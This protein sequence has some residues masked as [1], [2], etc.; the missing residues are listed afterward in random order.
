VQRGQDIVGSNG[1]RAVPDDQGEYRTGLGPTVLRYGTPGRVGLA[2]RE[3]GDRRPCVER[4]PTGLGHAL[5][6]HLRLGQE[7]GHGR[8]RRVEFDAWQLD[9][10]DAGLE[11]DREVR[12]R[13]LDRVDDVQARRQGGVERDAYGRRVA[14]LDERQLDVLRLARDTGRG[15]VRV[16]DPWV[17][18]E[19]AAVRHRDVRASQRPLEGALE[20]AGAGEP[21]A[22]PL[23]V[24][25]PDPLDRERGVAVG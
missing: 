25:Q 19:A 24:P 8:T 4:S 16:G 10:P 9:L 6:E 12:R 3:P 5:H 2:D 17:R 22:A 14:S 7:R 20:V 15:G 21:Q 13:C 11:P 18:R 23:G 1:R